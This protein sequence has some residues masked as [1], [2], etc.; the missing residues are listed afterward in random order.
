MYIF[1]DRKFIEK[2]LGNCMVH[3]TYS[4]LR[5]IS[6]RSFPAWEG[7]RGG[8]SITPLYWRMQGAWI[9]LS[10]IEGRD[11][12]HCVG[13]VLAKFIS[14]IYTLYIFICQ[15]FVIYYEILEIYSSFFWVLHIYCAF[16]AKLPYYKILRYLK[17]KS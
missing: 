3:L 16:I 10:D 13:L 17:G 5:A 15:N 1:T 6:Y 14:L 11:L 2:C 9:I 8:F 12:C 4:W 7:T